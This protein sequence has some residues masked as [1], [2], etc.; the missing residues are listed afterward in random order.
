MATITTQD[1]LQNFSNKFQ[2]AYNALPNLNAVGKDSIANE[3]AKTLVNYSERLAMGNG[4]MGADHFYRDP[5]SVIGDTVS[6]TLDVSGKP[7]NFSNN[8]GGVE[9]VNIS[10]LILQ[11][12]YQSFGLGFIFN[13]TGMDRPKTL[14]N[15]QSLR[16]ENAFGIF[17]A[18]DK[19]IDQRFSS[20]PMTQLT[21]NAVNE[22]ELEVNATKIDAS[23]DFKFPI[24]I[25]S[26]TLMGYE[27]ASKKWIK[28]GR[29]IQ[30]NNFKGIVAQQI[31]VADK[32]EID[33]N[34]GVITATNP[35]VVTGIEKFKWIAWKDVTKQ[36]DSEVPTVYPTADH[37]ELEA[38]PHY[39][40]IR[41]NLEDIVRMN[42]EYQVNKPNGIA[43]S[44]AKI[45]ISQLMS[46]YI[47]S[48]DTDIMNTMVTPFI[49]TILDTKPDT[50]FD[51]SNWQRSGN[52]NLLETRMTQM[53]ST[54]EAYMSGIADG[55]RPTSII[56]DTA[57]AVALM[58]NRFFKRAGNG[59]NYSDGL[60]GQLMGINIIRSRYLDYIFSPAWKMDGGKENI[61]NV[62][63]ELRNAL[64]PD[65]GE[66]ISVMFAVHKDQ[67][68]K[69]ASGVFGSYI[70][71][72]ATNGMLENGGLI[73]THTIAT[74]YT[75]A[76]VLPQLI[77]PMVVRTSGGLDYAGHNVSVGSA[78][79]VY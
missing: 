36:K 4:A 5:F 34:K 76:L 62:S 27:T 55:R 42:K 75:T 51:L 32:I 65:T 70:P 41:Q 49:P 59:F 73:M 28:M 30:V 21:G 29:D 54:V 6:A 40:R 37:I 68:N 69:T 16:A 44:Y 14:Y 72:Y 77:A 35:K 48:I 12:Q 23:T 15:F 19:I 26:L 74:E 7:E 33:Y 61:Y 52:T 17:N 67:A 57:G 3:Y 53:L 10:S 43:S 24:R 20:H 1:R 60:V 50:A 47:K 8:L 25:R 79:L 45:A 11:A 2:E 66:Q 64:S 38:R 71:A 22:K 46:G 13:M 56:T 58:S 18:D 31:S 9:S 63:E 78:G 39:F